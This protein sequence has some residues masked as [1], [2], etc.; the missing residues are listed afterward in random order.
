MS[1][2]KDKLRAETAFG[3]AAPT[4][5]SDSVQPDGEKTEKTET[6]AED[7]LPDIDDE[8]LLKIFNK[9]HKTTYKSLEELTKPTAETPAAA[10]AEPT[11][12]EKERLAQER[13]GKVRAFG[14][15]SK[16]VTADDLDSHARESTLSAYELGLQRYTHEHLEAARAQLKDGDSLPTAD[17]LQEEFDD[18]YQ[19]QRN[20][21]DPKKVY[22]NRLLEKEKER[23]LQEKYGHVLHLDQ[24]Y[25]AQQETTAARAQYDTLLDKAFTKLPKKLTHELTD[26]NVKHNYDFNFLEDV[27]NEVRQQYASEEMFAS[28]GRKKLTPDALAEAIKLTIIQREFPRMVSTIA[29]AHKSNA[30]LNRDLNRRGIIDNTS[31]FG[32]YD[33]GNDRSGSGLSFAARKLK[34]AK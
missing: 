18:L 15:N 13:R 26:G 14:L 10:A 30:T 34:E 4:P 24:D 16:K 20:D 8:Q 9:K 23:Y 7:N 25:D 1:N 32:G 33:A 11:A 31:G 5:T 12:E 6:A 17:E 28:F 27:L 19:Q 22:A 29:L 2:I 21:S 3:N